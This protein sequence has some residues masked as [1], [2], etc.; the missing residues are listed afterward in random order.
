MTTISKKLALIA[1]EK[2]WNI[3]IPENK[4]DEIFYILPTYEQLINWVFN[5]NNVKDHTPF[6]NIPEEFQKD[7]LKHLEFW[8]NEIISEVQDNEFV[9]EGF[10]GM[11]INWLLNNGIHL[12]ITSISQES[13]QYHVSRVGDS[14]GKLYEEDFYSKQE[15]RHEGILKCFQ[16]IKEQ[17]LNS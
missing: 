15:A 1:K 6:N 9:L 4:F 16:L 14:L 13:W 8:Y 3:K 10:V 12:T 17:N 5:D 2:G 7:I 11:L